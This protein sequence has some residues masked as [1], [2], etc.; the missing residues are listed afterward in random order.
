[1]LPQVGLMPYFIAKIKK[2]DT[3]MNLLTEPEK[4]GSDH[5]RKLPNLA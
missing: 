3:I 4:E 1:M 5:D 2:H